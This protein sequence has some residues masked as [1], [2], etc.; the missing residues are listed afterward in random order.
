M[1]KIKFL[2]KH[3]DQFQKMGVETI[4][5]FG[6]R[7][8]GNISPLS[9][10][11]I[12]VVF[13][14]PEQYKDKTMEP[15]LKLYDIFTEVLPKSYLKSR[16]EMREHE[17]D[18]VFLQFAPIKFQFNAIYN[19]IALYDKDKETRL[20]YKEYILKR[21]CDLKYFHDLRYQ[22]ILERI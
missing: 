7:V 21:Q 1:I 11:D 14:K 19:G 22:A 10:F 18:L 4:Y 6:S 15:Y 8:Q 17:F 13:E 3:I 2:P 9:D 5:L 16:F 12:G 20:S